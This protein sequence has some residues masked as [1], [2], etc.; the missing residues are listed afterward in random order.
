VDGDGGSFMAVVSPT[1]LVVLRSLDGYPVGLPVVGPD[2][3]GYQLVETYDDESGAVSTHVAVLNGATTVSLPGRATQAQGGVSLLAVAP[4]GTGLL[5]VTDSDGSVRG[6]AFNK[7]G[8]TLGT[9]TDRG[10]PTAAV[11]LGGLQG[12]TGKAFVFAPDGTAYVTLIELSVDEETG[13]S[14]AV[15]ST[16]YAMSSAGVT[17]VLDVPGAVATAPTVAPDG[18]EYVSTATLSGTAD[19]VTTV[20]VITPPSVV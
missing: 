10:T 16:V 19:G 4:D 11:E 2:G 3:T 6:L 14:T 5:I 12:L 20:K 8:A 9:F 18:T 1:G 15:G 7:T 13:E 17:K